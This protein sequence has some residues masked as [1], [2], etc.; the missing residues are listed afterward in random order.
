MNASDIHTLSVYVANKPG[1]LARIAQVFARRGFNIDSLVVSSSV[2]GNFSRMT[3]TAQGDPAGLQQVIE[4]LRKL[5][6]VLH[7]VDHTNEDVVVRELALAKVKISPEERT[8]A[9]QIAD[10]FGAKTVDL[11]E[12]SMI[13]MVTGTT[14]KLDAMIGLVKKFQVIELVRT[15]K[16]VMA[17]GGEET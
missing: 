4:A 11:T 5:I 1:V 10:H 3:I 15:G 16:V 14:D 7:C 2:D 17:R 12:S 6:D 8:E 13:L 9:L